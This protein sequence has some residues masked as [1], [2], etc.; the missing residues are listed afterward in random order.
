MNKCLNINTYLYLAK[1]KY[2][3]MQYTEIEEPISELKPSITT[4]PASI[5]LETVMDTSSTLSIIDHNSGTADMDSTT[6]KP[7]SKH[8]L[9]E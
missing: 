1:K 5:I 7:L 9:D 6:M 2:I 8:I 4:K 3:Y